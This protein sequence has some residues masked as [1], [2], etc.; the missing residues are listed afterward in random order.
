MVGFGTTKF[1]RAWEP[2]LL[3]NQL[4]ALRDRGF[5]R[6]RLID[7]CPTHPALL[8]CFLIFLLRREECFHPWSASPKQSC[9]Q[10]Q[11]KH[12][13]N[14]EDGDYQVIAA[15]IIM[16]HQYAALAQ[17]MGQRKKPLGQ[18]RDFDESPAN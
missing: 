18:V 1:T 4:R 5:E 7:S 15:P 2:A 14:K 17:V 8:R 6:N 10:E 13:E 16:R 11:G 12:S 9:G 3:W